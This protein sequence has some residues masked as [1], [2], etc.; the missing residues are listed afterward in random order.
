MSETSLTLRGIPADATVAG[1][2]RTATD[3]RVRSLVDAHYEFVWR[4][5][6]RIGVPAGDVDDGVQKVFLIAASKID[7]IRAGSEQ[8]FLFQ[9]A[10]RVASDYRR[11]R[12]RRPEV[13]DEGIHESVDDSPGAEELL[14]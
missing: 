5:L 7:A 10:I 12:R 9:T 6:R 11:S 8:S 14:D 2:V 3:A 13:S 1:E 4:A